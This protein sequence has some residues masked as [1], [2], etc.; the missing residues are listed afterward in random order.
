MALQLRNVHVGY[1]GAVMGLAGLGLT[2]RSAAPLFPGVFRAPAYFTEPWIAAA[3]IALVALVFLYSAKLFLNPAAVKE[4]FTSPGLL[5]FCGAFPVGM[6][7]VAGG[8]GPYAPGFADALWWLGCAVLVVFQVWALS[9][10]LAGSLEFTKFNAG[11]LIILVGGIVV[12]GPGIAL[13]EAEAARAF[14]GVSASVAPL[15]MALLLYRA[16]ALSPLPEG[17]RPTWF[18]LLVPPSLIYAN[19]SALYNGFEPLENLFYFDVV[20]ALAL[21]FYARRLVRWPF[22]PAWWAFTFPLDALAYAAVHFA[23]QHPSALWRAVA[24]AALLLATLFVSV[25]LL[26]SL[27]AILRSASSPPA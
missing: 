22:G 5:G 14:F 13:G 20:L 18:I 11:W 2:A 15:L 27:A 10:L 4:D 16:A 7:L 21:F 19:G 6:T 9:R 24:G 26:R 3:L 25:V 23:Q 17:L 8:L 1:Y 12:P